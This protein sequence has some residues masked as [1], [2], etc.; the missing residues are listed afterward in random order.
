MSAG[1]LWLIAILDLAVIVLSLAFY[2]QFLAIC[3]DEE[4]ARTRGRPRRGVLPVIADADRADG[5]V[6]GRCGRHRAGHCDADLLTP[7]TDR[8]HTSSKVLRDLRIRWYGVP[9]V[10]QKVHPQILQR[11]RRPVP[12][13]TWKEPFP[14]IL[15]L[16][17]RL[18]RIIGTCC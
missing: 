16:P 10:E 12:R 2:K 11:Y 7:L 8:M 17:L 6:V 1:G 5:V 15:P 3:F 4:F 13:F 9:V 18:T 14:M